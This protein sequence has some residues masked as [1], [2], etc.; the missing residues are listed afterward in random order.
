MTRPREGFVGSGS[1]PPAN[2]VKVGRMAQ[3]EQSQSHSRGRRVLKRV[4]I[5]FGLVRRR[6]YSVIGI[7]ATQHFETK[8]T[9]SLH[10]DDEILLET[11]RNVP[12]I[13]ATRD[14]AP[15]LT[16]L[17][18]PGELRDLIFRQ[19]F[20]NNGTSYVTQQLLGFPKQDY[21]TYSRDFQI[22]LT[23]RQIY[24]EAFSHAYRLSCFYWFKSYTTTTLSKLCKSL[25]DRQASNVRHIAFWSNP[26]LCEGFVDDLPPA[27]ALTDVTVCSNYMSGAVPMANIITRIAWLM[28]SIKKL[29]TLKRFHFLTGSGIDPGNRTSDCE[30]AVHVR[31]SFA[32]RE[33]WK[34]ETK[35]VDVG[36]FDPKTFVAKVTISSSD[37]EGSSELDA[38]ETRPR[39]EVELKIASVY[40]EGFG[41]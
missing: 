1:P 35:D 36:P 17:G 26:Y 29:K 28:R 30:F 11:P 2:S 23:C 5:L 4:K 33:L 27:L 20:A 25:T 22:L 13:E 18:L 19:V 16:L 41:D 31:R 14:A 10:D 21:S 6:S 12:V 24:E 3:P 38:K 39:R 37:I 40:E 7:P 9:P 32:A 8:E 15:Q 34:L